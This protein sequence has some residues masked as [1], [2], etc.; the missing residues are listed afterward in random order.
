M[1]VKMLKTG[2][3]S[4]NFVATKLVD[5]EVY[6]NLPLDVIDHIIKVK[7]GVLLVED[8]GN[9]IVEEPRED[10]A[11]KDM[12]FN[13]LKDLA[14]SKGLKTEGLKSKVELIALIGA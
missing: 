4:I 11:L 2:N 6:E 7:H 1:K 9:V 14:K 10:K 8:A 5:G 12:K 3:W 13:E